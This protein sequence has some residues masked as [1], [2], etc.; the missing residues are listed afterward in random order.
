MKSGLAFLACSL[1]SVLRK[2]DV[3]RRPEKASASRFTEKELSI[4]RRHFQRHG[5]EF[6]HRLISR[7]TLR[8][9][10][11]KAYEMGLK[12]GQSYWTEEENDLILIFLVRNPDATDADI[13]AHLESKGYQRTVIAVRDRRLSLK[14]CLRPITPAVELS[15]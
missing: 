12:R 9:I 15:L 3:D 14:S 7:H 6:C 5:A 13:R 8:S 11:K 4:I 1:Q 10:E 2:Y